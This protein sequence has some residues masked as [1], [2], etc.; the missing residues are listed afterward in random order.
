MATVF[1]SLLQCGFVA[2]A[3]ML[4]LVAQAH[5]LFVVDGNQSKDGKVHVY[6]SEEAAADNPALL[7]KV[8]GA[9]V[10]EANL[11][12]DVVKAVKLAH[13]KG[14]DSLVATPSEKAT[15]AGVFHDY[16]VMSKGGA[17]PYLLRYCGRSQTIAN[18]NGG[19]TIN[20]AALLPLEV[21]AQRTP[22]GFVVRTFWQGQPAEGIEVVVDSDKLPSQKEGVSN[23]QGEIALGKLEDGLY[24]L[25][26]KKSLDEPGKLGDKEYKSIRIY[27][28]NSLLIKPATPAAKPAAT[29][30]LP[31]LPKGITSFGGAI[32]GDVV[33]VYGGHMGGA[34]HYAKGELST[35]LW[36]LDLKN[37]SQ[38]QV[39]GSGPERAGLT[40]VAVGN[41]VYRLGGFAAENAVGEDDILKSSN[42]FARW[43]AASKSWVA[44]PSLP[45]GRSSLDAVSLGST[46]YAIGGWELKGSGSSA[47]W[48]TTAW[49]FDVAA[50][51]PAWTEI[52]AP[53]FQRRALSAAVHNGKIYVIGGMQ[54]KGGPTTKVAIY[55]PA[56]N[57]WGDG[58]ELPGK[59]MEGFG[60]SS[61]A[62]GGDLYVSVMSGKVYKLTA[63]GANWEQVHQLKQPRFFHRMLPTND[64]KLVFVGGASMENGKADQVEIFE[65]K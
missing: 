1:R 52:A 49:K 42:D 58:P 35:E 54:N 21:V 59:G 2:V 55:D 9:T 53:P 16:G 14:A 36:S 15:N 3:A 32:V 8:L 57:T 37:P 4:P 10:W 65:L 6:F 34:H 50:P 19:K 28:T 31:A 17:E 23:E 61:F 44:L 48:H 5:F 38:W 63:D 26:A 56:A 33:Y 46:I 29:S 27:S 41:D 7:D 45:E 13:E 43:D 40:M 24:S 60:S 11:H 51:T 25:R 18:R 30:A 64:H 62:S 12:D 47:Q 39:L 20:D 22:E